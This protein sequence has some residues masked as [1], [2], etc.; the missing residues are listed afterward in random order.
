MFNSL[1]QFYLMRFQPLKRGY[2]RN[3]SLPEVNN[4]HNVHLPFKSRKNIKC[5]I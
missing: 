4:Y 1:N 3:D 2:M 5:K